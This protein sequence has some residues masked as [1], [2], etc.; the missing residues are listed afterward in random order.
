MTCMPRFD[1]GTIVPQVALPTPR[2]GAAH[3]GAQG[4][5][6]TTSAPHGDPRRRLRL[7]GRR[8]ATASRS[9][10]CCA[11]TRATSPP[12]QAVTHAQVVRWLNAARRHWEDWARHC[13]YDGPDRE[14]VVRS[15][16]VLKGLTYEPS[17]AIVAAPTT[18]L[19]ERIGGALNWDYRFAWPRDAVVRPERP[20]LARL[21][22]GGA[23]VP[24]LARLDGGGPRAR[25]P[26]RL[27][28][29]RRA[30][31]HRVR[32]ARARGL[33]GQP[34]RPHRQRRARRSSSSTST[35]RSS[36]PCS[37]AR[38][39]RASS[40]PSDGASSRGSPTSSSSTGAS[41]TRAS[42][43]RAAGAGTTC[44]RR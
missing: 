1:Y 28:R 10:P 12:S 15:A 22:R 41:P 26:D 24:P 7:R 21:L 27:R 32:A 5:S 8:S 18:S 4:L 35:A 14:R 33:P 13:V 20:L 36:T 44:T 11:T 29:R 37:W 40:I 30:P 25:P 6:L 23:G 9:S 19:P 42:G 2:F 34:P 38:S 31:A 16:L 17:G 3:G 43:R 39:A